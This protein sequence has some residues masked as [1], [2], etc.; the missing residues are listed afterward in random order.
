[1]LALFPWSYLPVACSTLVSRLRSNDP[2]R[3]TCP[4]PQARSRSRSSSPPPPPRPSRAS[5]ICSARA[6]RSTTS[7]AAWGRRR[8]RPPRHTTRPTRPTRSHPS[9]SRSS[10]ARAGSPSSPAGAASSSASRRPF[11]HPHSPRPHLISPASRHA[12]HRLKNNG[13]YIRPLA[14]PP[15]TA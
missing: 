15:E 4:C 14:H 6:P 11:V 13:K 1:P 2:R 8:S 3:C 7:C 5:S 9:Q 12:Q 10:P